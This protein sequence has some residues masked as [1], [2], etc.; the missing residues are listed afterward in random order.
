VTAALVAGPF[1]VVWTGGRAEWPVT[2]F[3]FV[4]AMFG[5]WS[6]FRIP[7]TYVVISKHFGVMP[8]I[9]FVE[10]AV[11][12]LLCWLLL[13]SR[14]VLVIP[15]SAILCHLCFSSLVGILYIR[16]GLS[17]GF[18]AL[19]RSLA[20]PSLVAII[21]TPCGLLVLQSTMNLA[22]GPCLLA[23]STMLLPVALLLFVFVGLDRN[24]REEFFRTIRSFCKTPA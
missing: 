13:P 16:K 24:L 5:T 1:V 23:R 19:L 7:S 22:P 9:Y 11:F 10:T 12:V 20:R 8:Y 2:N 18:A 15:A 3:L 4:A 17:F 14:G 21:L 6:V